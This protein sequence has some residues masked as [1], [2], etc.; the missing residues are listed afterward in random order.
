MSDSAYI[1]SKPQEENN[2][3]NSLYVS[4]V[5]SIIDKDYDATDW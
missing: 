5:F 3:K 4:W 2:M 1:Y